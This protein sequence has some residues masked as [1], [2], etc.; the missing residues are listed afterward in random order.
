MSGPSDI[1]SIFVNLFISRKIDRANLTIR[2]AWSVRR[3]SVNISRK[4]TVSNGKFLFVSRLKHPTYLCGSPEFPM[5]LHNNLQLSQLWM[6]WEIKRKKLK[7][8][9]ETTRFM[10]SPCCT[11][12][13]CS[14]LKTRDILAM[15]SNAPYTVS[16]RVNT[17]DG[18]LT[19]PQAVNPTIFE[20][21]RHNS[22][23]TRA[24]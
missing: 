8:R 12:T 21:I 19:L 9:C 16:K 6:V 3:R 10:S 14:P 11:K 23:T 4:A 13:H 24:S 20:W 18:S 1:S 7:R 17:C 15:R 22:L 2:T 5:L